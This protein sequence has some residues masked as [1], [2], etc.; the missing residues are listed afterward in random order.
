M[1]RKTALLF[2]FVLFLGKVAM[3]QEMVFVQ[4]GTFTMGCTLAQKTGCDVGSCCDW[5]LPNRQV[6]LSDYSIGKYEVTQGEWKV[7]FGSNPSYFIGCGDNC[8]VEQVSWFDA[9]VYCNRLSESKGYT[10][11]Y[12]TN[13]NFTQIY[14]KS[15]NTWSL[16][17]QDI[18]I[19]WREDAN[20]YHLPT[21]A[22]WEYAARGGYKSTNKEFAGSNSIGD[23]AW[24][25]DNSQVTYT[26]NLQNKGTHTK[27]TKNANELGI[28]DMSGNV[29]EWCFDTYAGGA[30]P[31][32]NDCC[33]PT[34]PDGTTL[35]TSAGGSYRI[36]RGGS[37]VTFAFC[38]RVS[39]RN[40][41]YPYNRDSNIGFRL[42]RSQ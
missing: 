18:T 34:A 37:W 6:S 4:G 13:A 15:G 11:C 42:C 22:Q 8:P 41:Y 36:G 38:S 24:Y 25:W 40:S 9:L 10:P 26:P 35:H 17:N 1:W 3:A 20:G 12:Y 27:G 39:F 5:E 14:G 19:Y 16:P 30:Y 29:W 33:N 7:L 31:N 2:I 28:F 23:V 32:T 21:E